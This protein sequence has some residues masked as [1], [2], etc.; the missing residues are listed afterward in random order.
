MVGAGTRRRALG[1]LALVIVLGVGLVACKRDP[2]PQARNRVAW[3]HNASRIAAGH[4]AYSVD[5]VVTW[6]AQLAANRLSAE[7]GN[8]GCVLNHTPDEVL[9]ADYP[10]RWGENIGCF[11]GCG[12]AAANATK[13]FLDSEAHRNNILSD[14]YRRFGVGVACNQRYLFV[15]VQFSY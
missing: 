1:A 4:S 10:D 15:A 8:T 3:D 14:T 13:S 12:G 9:R 5:D 11:P 6:N 7:S 2:G